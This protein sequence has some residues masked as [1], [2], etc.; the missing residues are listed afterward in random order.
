MGAP[1]RKTVQGGGRL[2]I[3]AWMAVV[4]SGLLITGCSSEGPVTSDGGAAASQQIQPLDCEAPVGGASTAGT[5]NP[6]SVQDHLEKATQSMSGGVVVAL[7]TA[8]GVLLCAAGRADSAGTPL[9]TGDV[10]RIASVTKTFTAVLVMQLVEEGRVSLE[11]QVTDVLPNLTMAKGV[12]VRQL[13]NHS[14]G[15]PEFLDTSFEQAVRE[16]FARSWTAAE[17]VARLDKG[18]R[19]FEPPGAQHRYSN[20]NYL[21]AGM[22]VEEVTGQPLSEVLRARITEP[23]GMGHTGLGP[24]R[25][26]PVTGFAPALPGGN[27]EGISYRALET[28]TG[29][30]GGMV[31][32]AADLVTFATA[33]ADG[34]LVSAESL[35]EMTDF[36]L[37][38]DGMGVGLGLMQDEGGMIH[39]E[40]RL[41]GYGS[42]MILPSPT[43]DMVVV[44]S[45]DMYVNIADLAEDLMPTS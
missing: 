11:D 27:T 8:E 33:L 43:N 21:V 36:S 6:L 3:R 40:G 4:A 23:L 20:T 28:A 44:L 22:L 26:E 34:Q 14:S 38:E 24:D 45:N 1:S 29:A 17:V 16:D 10:F 2:M 35:A 39:H 42:L 13:L 25:P 7:G 19:E 32:T 31:S 15:L 9:S 5:A 37:A 30:A 18:E 41:G 12:T